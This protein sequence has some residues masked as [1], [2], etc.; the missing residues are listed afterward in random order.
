MKR[1][2]ADKVASQACPRS[3]ESRGASMAGWSGYLLS[4]LSL[5]SLH[6]TAGPREA[7]PVW[8]GKLALRRLT[9]WHVAPHRM[10]S[11]YLCPITDIRS[12]SDA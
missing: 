7:V 2:A 4:A 12:L 3:D 6:D 11:V 9:P 8:Q 5:T 1:H 10:T